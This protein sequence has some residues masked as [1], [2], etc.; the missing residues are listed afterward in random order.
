MADNGRWFKLW[1]T[2]ITDNRLASLPNDLWAIWAKLGAYIKVH[3]NEGEIVIVKPEKILCSI[4]QCDDFTTLINAVK[5]FPNVTVTPVTNTIVT[6]RLKYEN[7]YKYQ[8]DFS[9][10]RVK[11][12]RAKNSKSVTPKKRR[13]EK[14]GEETR[15]E[16]K[17]N[18]FI[19]PSLNE[20]SEYCLERKNNIND[21]AFLDFY[22]S[23]GWM[24][25]KNK[26]KDWKAAIRTWEK[27]KKQEKK[28][29]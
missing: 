3:G 7:W 4:L 21:Q 11:N 26:M 10:D 23:K 19:P 28:Y 18:I 12:F 27:S 16:E 24:I 8:G 13:E 14:R 29:L 6:Y 22:E 15:R 20:I 25:G 17:R 5:C 9:G 1:T 2:A